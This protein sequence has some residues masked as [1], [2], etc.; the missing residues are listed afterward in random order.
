MVEV[1]AGQQ[2][3]GVWIAPAA[4]DVVHP[5]PVTVEAVRDSVLRDRRQRSQIRHVGP[6]P[7]PGGEV[8]RVDLS[9]FAGVESLAGVRRRP[10]IHVSHLRSVRADDTPQVSS[11]DVPAPR[12]SRRYFELSH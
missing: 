11:G 3:V 4:D 9:R 2:V 10:A 7:I 8:R 5:R 6:E 1:L 12:V